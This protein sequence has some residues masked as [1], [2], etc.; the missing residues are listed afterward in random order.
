L[1]EIIIPASVEVLGDECFC[2]C[3]RLQ[4]VTFEPGSRLREVGRKAFSGVAVHP[5]FP[6]KKC[7]LW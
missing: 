7:C 5:T 6:N 2:K 1:I 4:S 3:I